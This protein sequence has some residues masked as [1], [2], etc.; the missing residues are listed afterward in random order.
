MIDIKNIFSKTENFVYL[1]LYIFGLFLPVVRTSSLLLLIILPIRFLFAKGIFSLFY[2]LLS[3]KYV[4][5]LLLLYFIIIVYSLWTTVIFGQMDFSLI[6]TLINIILH[7]FVGLLLV[8]FFNYKKYSRDDILQLLIRIFIIQSVIQIIAFCF[9]PLQTFVQYFQGEGTIEL[10]S[11]FVGR[12]GLALAGT[13]F[14]GLSTLYGLVFLFFVRQCCDSQRFTFQDIIVGVILLVGGFF[15]GR[16]FFIGLGI[17]GI[18]FLCSSF[19][20]RSKILIL[21]KVL[22]LLIGII[23]VV[24]MLLPP[25]FYDQIYNL[26]YYVFE[27]AFNYFQFGEL[28]TTSS[29]HLLNNM[30]FEVSLKTFFFGDGRY[31]GFDGAYYM[32]TDAGFLRNILFF[33]IGG[34]ILLCCTDIYLLFGNKRVRSEG[35]LKFSIFIFLYMAIIHIKG[36]VFGYLIMLHCFLFVY[37]FYLGTSDISNKR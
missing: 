26:L 12:R 34:L 6:P 4:Y 2:K 22:L 29:E 33:G 30:Y 20:I 1:F 9:V 31:T 23:W 3:T 36:E 37:Y 16:T 32:H 7:L 8:S 17:A 13:V 27:F 5:K 11:Q 25:E 10:A 28:T 15:T 19:S 35:N 24:W 18:Y 21:F 14:F